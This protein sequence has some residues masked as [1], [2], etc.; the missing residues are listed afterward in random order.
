ME[1]YLSII[2]HI[3]SRISLD[4]KMTQLLK[5]SVISIH[6]VVIYHPA[7][8]PALISATYYQNYVFTLWNFTYVLQKCLE[9]P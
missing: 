9:L 4:E 8:T 6:D 7:E 3:K 5:F 1:I 2:V